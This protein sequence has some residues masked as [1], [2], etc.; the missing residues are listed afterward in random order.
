MPL[1]EKGC[2]NHVLEGVCDPR[3]FNLGIPFSSLEISVS[4]SNVSGEEKELSS[5]SHFLEK[6]AESQAESPCSFGGR[7]LLN[8]SC[9]YF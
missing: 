2:E 4:T 5:T 3:K 7:V 9:R 8:F 6:Q 1:G